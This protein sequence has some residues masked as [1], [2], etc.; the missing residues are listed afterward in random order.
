MNRYFVAYDSNYKGS[1]HM[2]VAKKVAD[3]FC[4]TKIKFS[5]RETTKDSKKRTYNYVAVKENN[6][7]KI[8]RIVR[9]GG[10]MLDEF[11]LKYKGEYFK[12]T[13][14]YISPSFTIKEDDTKKDEIVPLYVNKGA[15]GLHNIYYD[16][17]KRQYIV[18]RTA[19][20]VEQFKINLR[21]MTIQNIE[22]NHIFDIEE[23]EK[24]VRSRSRSKTR[25]PSPSK[26]PARKRSPPSDKKKKSVFDNP[27]R[28]GES[29]LNDR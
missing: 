10:G 9:Q 20:P 12:P 27:W 15:L 16:K 8:K 4:N 3:K 17:S 13:G 28:S 19:R 7:V 1:S 26:S 11:R 2:S 21:D 25:S 24:R 29:Y 14:Y 5:V 18:I 6:N 23:M 22:T